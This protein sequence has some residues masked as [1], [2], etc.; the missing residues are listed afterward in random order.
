MTGR[1]TWRVESVLSA[2]AALRIGGSG[3]SMRRRLVFSVLVTTLA[4]TTVFGV[5][6]AH[7]T[8][9]RKRVRL[10]AGG[11][12]TFIVWPRGGSTAYDFRGSHF[13][14][15]ASTIVGT[16][17]PDAAQAAMSLGLS[18]SLLL[19]DDGTVLGGGRDD[20]GQ[21]GQ[22][23]NVGT[24]NAN[25]FGVVGTAT[26]VAAGG[27]HSLLLQADGTVLALGRNTFGELGVTDAQ[28]TELA[29]PVPTVVPGLSDVVAISAGYTHSL[30]VRRDGTVWSW[31][32][33]QGGQLGRATNTG[34][35]APNPEATQVAGLTG[36]IDVAGGSG[37]SLALRAD[38]TVWSWGTNQFGQLGRS[39]NL[40]T[41]TAN[42]TPTQIDGLTDIRS[43]AAGGGLAAALRADGTV[44]S[45]GENKLGQLGRTDGFGATAATPGAVAIAGTA[46][47]IGAG[48]NHLVIAY[49]DGTVRGFGSNVAGQ[50]VGPYY[51]GTP[52]TYAGATD[53]YTQSATRFPLHPFT[54][55]TLATGQTGT[56]AALLNLTMTEGVRTGYITADSCSALT[57]G[58]Q[59][60]SN[61]NYTRNTSIANLAV[62]PFDTD[63][64]ACIVN[65][66]PVNII[67]DLQGAFTPSAP[68][69]F[70]ALAPT[71]VLDTRRGP[72]PAAGT[73]V[74]V[75][76]GQTGATSA[77]VN[78]TMTE[79]DT[80]GYITADRCSTLTAGPQTKS[81]GNYT[82]GT[83]IANLAVVP[84]DNDGSFCIYTERTAHLLVDLQGT[85]APGG[86]LGFQRI[87]PTRLT[88]T[89]LG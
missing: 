84:L 48:A 81:N 79:A 31:G 35:N 50:V 54:R 10:A 53:P 8:A 34:T 38:G 55:T 64:T 73:I 66:Q 24:I 18:H 56:G 13:L 40:G 77:L 58:P 44:F 33:N 12:Q 71:R 74:R 30:A 47:A 62:V 68:D 11:D 37:F 88:D 16:V 26:A 3:M 61:G 41:L 6:P 76:T 4:A 60:R 69:R 25:G 67:A 19:L 36:V 28:S 7:A 78:L 86:T 17:R 57:A 63:G 45:W 85:F 46:V 51:V 70:T 9:A 27:W 72:K 5:G 87:D 14:E 75:A 82:P 1:V 29:R 32:G 22:R 23:D 2:I 39:T 89:R 49:D 83:N 20:Y 59:T 21:I 42:P 65:E 80:A 43:L 15:L 52:L